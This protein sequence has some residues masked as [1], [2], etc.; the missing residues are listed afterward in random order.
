MAENQ[1]RKYVRMIAIREP[2]KPAP[3][4]DPQQEIEW[5]CECLGLGDE[6]DQLAKEIFKSLVK[7]P[8]EGVTTREI[9]DKAHV[10]QGAVVYHMNI[11]MRSGLVVK[12]GRR[13]YFMRPSLDDTLNEIE[14]YMIRRMNLL[15]EMARRL[16]Q[17]M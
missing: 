14:Q 13:Y 5:M 4:N 2:A 16:E 3:R 17:E 6:R 10:T 11:F 9:K 15:R 7:A 12:D 8:R 1:R